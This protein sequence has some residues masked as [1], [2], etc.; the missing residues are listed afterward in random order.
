MEN[1]IDEIQTAGA[2]ELADGEVVDWAVALEFGELR[3]LL[4]DRGELLRI[5]F[6]DDGG[7]GGFEGRKW[8]LLSGERRR[9]EG[10]GE[11]VLRIF[12]DGRHGWNEKK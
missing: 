3:T 6:G 1:S 4:E 8:R 9:E 11:E 12:D 7:F 5:R 10:S 2:S